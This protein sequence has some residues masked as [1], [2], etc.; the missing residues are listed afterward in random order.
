MLENI[1]EHS[2]MVASVAMTILD[3][4][5]L[6]PEQLPDAELII[7]G[8]LLHDIAKTKCLKD[9]CNHAEVGQ[10]ICV[11]EG[12]P[13]VG[14]IV[15]EHVILH[16]FDEKRYQQGVFS[17]KDI[18]YYSDKRVNH[19]QIV[20]LDQRLEYIMERYGNNDAVRHLLIKKNFQNCLD[21]EQYIFTH[22]GFS[23]D[24]LYQHVS[25]L[26]VVLA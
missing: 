11:Q 23:P 14:E 24:Q 9:D 25:P 17:G 10:Q 15:S 7:A 22:M 20:T 3:G 19:T 16:S 6:P 18:I 21:L 5:S 1:R 8:A 4:L 13:E 26:T 2:L 12:Y